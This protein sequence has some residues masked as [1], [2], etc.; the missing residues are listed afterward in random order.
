MALAVFTVS[1]LVLGYL[2]LMPVT[3]TYTF[4]S[5]VFTATYF[6]FF[7]FMPFYTTM[8]KPKPVP[9]RVT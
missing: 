5:R 9:D 3:D 6:A 4:Y 7:I 1:F 2:G 8:E